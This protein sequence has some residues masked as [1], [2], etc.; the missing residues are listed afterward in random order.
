MEFSEPER[1]MQY[2]EMQER[3][4]SLLRTFRSNCELRT[5]A[6]CTEKEPTV[7]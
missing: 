6:A 7:F 2:R 1:E 5:A 3:R 4:K